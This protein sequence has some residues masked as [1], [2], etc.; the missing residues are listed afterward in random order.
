[1]CVYNCNWY[2]I[3]KTNLYI[4]NNLTDKNGLNIKYMRVLNILT[5]WKLVKFG[6]ISIRVYYNRYKIIFNI[7]INIK[8]GQA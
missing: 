7:F 5:I 8:I 2:I 6:F 3:I 1:M 4:Y